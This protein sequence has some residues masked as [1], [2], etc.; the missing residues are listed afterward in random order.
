MIDHQYLYY[1][2]CQ[3]SKDAVLKVRAPFRSTARKINGKLIKPFLGDGYYFWEHNIDVAHFWGNNH[4]NNDYVI[5]EYYGLDRTNILDFND[6]LHWEYFKELQERLGTPATS[7]YKYLSDWINYFRKL[8]KESKNLS[9][10]PFNVLRSDEHMD[11][12]SKIKT[13]VKKV[14]FVDRTPYYTIQNRLTIICVHNFQNSNM[15]LKDIIR[16]KIS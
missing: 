9:V 11:S 3:D 1:H 2:T 12:N 13:I 7:K 16:D 10:F 6:N 14:Y 8:D 5:T 15:I 4:Y